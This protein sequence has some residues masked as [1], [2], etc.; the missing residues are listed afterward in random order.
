MEIAF[1]NIMNK[2]MKCC[3]Y[4]ANPAFQKPSASISTSVILPKGAPISAK[5]PFA[6]LNNTWRNIWPIEKRSFPF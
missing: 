6:S 3:I 4:Y 2:I 5:I 1:I